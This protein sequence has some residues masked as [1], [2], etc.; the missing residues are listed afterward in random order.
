MPDIAGQ[1][2]APTSLAQASHSSDTVASAKHSWI[3]NSSCANATV[4]LILCPD[5]TMAR[6]SIFSSN[7]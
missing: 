3:G 6:D 4:H 7:E 2:P 1:R 5:P